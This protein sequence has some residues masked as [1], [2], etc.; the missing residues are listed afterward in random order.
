MKVIND[1]SDQ[2]G[3]VTCLTGFAVSRLCRLATCDETE[4]TLT[5]HWINLL[6]VVKLSLFIVCHKNLQK[7]FYKNWDDVP[8][9]HLNRTCMHSL[10]GCGVFTVACLLWRV[11]CGVLT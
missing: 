3:T 2:V 5:K 8:K 4:A 10:T 9:I 7:C 11:Y 1:N 6:Y